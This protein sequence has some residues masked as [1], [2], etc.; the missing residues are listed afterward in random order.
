MRN[1]CVPSILFLA[2]AAQAFAQDTPAVSL[3]MLRDEGIEGFEQL[4]PIESG[5]RTKMHGAPRFGWGL[6]V[7]TGAEIE[8]IIDAGSGAASAF[9]SE[10]RPDGGS[11]DW[12]ERIDWSLAGAT[13]RRDSA[14]AFKLRVPPAPGSYEFNLTLHTEVRDQAK[15]EQAARDRA[16][17]LTLLVEAP[18]DAEGDGTIGGYP[19]GIYPN[20]RNRR[21]P[22]IVMNHPDLYQPPAGF[23]YVTPRIHGVKISEHFTLGD[24]VPVLERERPHYIVIDSRLVEALETAIERLRPVFATPAGVNPL[25]ILIGFL[26]PNQLAQL[27]KRGVR[28][29]EFSRYQYGDGVSVVWDADGDGMMD[30]LDGDG[31]IDV[32]DARRLAD[33]FD[34]I[35]RSLR[36]FGGVGVGAKP[37]IPGLPETPYVDIDMRGF[38]QRW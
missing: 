17:R 18:F 16:V 7:E 6:P 31:A 4:P 13:L 38:R 1:F 26:S 30:D 33:E 9:W 3:E 2:F 25:K 35:Q 22:S 24:F 20:P 34:T 10:A 28:V 36:K 27:D 8:F 23:I 32:N 11:L 12:V 14:G 21:A 29:A 15:I 19:I 37:K 5:I